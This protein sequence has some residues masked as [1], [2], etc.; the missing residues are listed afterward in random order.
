MNTAAKG[1]RAEYKSRKLFEALGY[2][3]I[4]AAASKGTF[5][6]ACFGKTDVKLIQVKCGNKPSK[7]E[8]KAMQDFPQGPFVVKLVHIWH[9][10]AKEPEVHY[11]NAHNEAELVLNKQFRKPSGFGC[12][13][14]EGQTCIRCT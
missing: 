9:A 10:R 13:C 12:A 4:R 7:K 11:I 5:D 2:R 1:R 8:F 3:V 14:L 6:L